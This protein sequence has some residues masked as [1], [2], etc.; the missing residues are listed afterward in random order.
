MLNAQICFIHCIALTCTVCINAQFE[1]IIHS[2]TY[3]IAVLLWA[4]CNK[5]S[6]LDVLCCSA[7]CVPVFKDAIEATAILWRIIE[8]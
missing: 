1:A 7:L 8:P 6:G 4:E 3:I 2:N 5:G